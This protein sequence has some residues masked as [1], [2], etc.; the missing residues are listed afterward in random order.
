MAT[1]VP[2]VLCL[3]GGTFDP[4]HAGHL[5]VATAVRDI[6]DTKVTLLPGATPPHRDAPDVTFLDRLAMVRLAIAGIEGL[7]CS[8]LEHHLPGPSYSVQT[9][10][11]LRAQL[12]GKASLIWVLGADAAAGLTHWREA[13]RLAGL[14][15][16]LVV[17]RPGYCAP[18]DTAR[19]L[20]FTRQTPRQLV[21]QDRGG[22]VEVAVPPHPASATAVRAAIRV[23]RHSCWLP[24][25]VRAYI[26]QNN[27]YT[28]AD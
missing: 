3:Y 14:A 8:D 20:G 2:E 23:D 19:A 21:T 5:H 11:H 18:P 22:W 16:V 9:L 7:A 1:S 24:E 13:K 26:L 28:I 6:L 10:S 4:I 15:H 25:G 17:N 12:G 27:L